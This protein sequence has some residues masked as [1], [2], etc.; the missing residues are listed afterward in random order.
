[1]YKV[2]RFQYHK[3]CSIVE[4]DSLIMARI[5]R[6]QWLLNNNSSARIIYTG[7]DIKGASLC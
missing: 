6:K 4:F 2:Q 1:M 7:N 3:L 5:A